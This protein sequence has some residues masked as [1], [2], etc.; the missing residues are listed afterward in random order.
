MS[1]LTVTADK[2]FLEDYEVGE[3]LISPARTLTESDVTNFAGLTGDWH[4][5]HT[6]AVYAAASPFGQRIVHGMLTFAIGSTLVLRLGPYAYLD[7]GVWLGYVLT[8]ATALGIETCAMASVAA[9]PEPLR[10]MLPIAETDIILFGLV[11][12]HGDT[13]APANACRTTREPVTA[14]VTFVGR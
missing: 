7:V 14:N 1:T 11:L 3:T 13:R 2:E 10:T 4:P 5:L 9:Y 12:G 6:D 8:A